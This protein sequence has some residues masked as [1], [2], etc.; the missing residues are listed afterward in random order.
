MICKH[1]LTV[2]IIIIYVKPVGNILVVSRNVVIYPDNYII[3]DGISAAMVKLCATMDTHPQSY[4][5]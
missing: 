2:S 1:I 5:Y 4:K 3:C